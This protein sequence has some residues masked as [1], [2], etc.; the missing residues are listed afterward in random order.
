MPGRYTRWGSKI[1]MSVMKIQVKL[2]SCH[3]SMEAAD[4]PFQRDGGQGKRHLEV[5]ARLHVRFF[6][7]ERRSEMSK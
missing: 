4:I 1:G 5:Q 6:Q 7:D 2:H 3:D